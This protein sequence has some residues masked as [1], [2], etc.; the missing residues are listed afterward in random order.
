MKNIIQQE[1]KKIGKSQQQLAK[2]VG[3]T[4]PALSNIERGEVVPSGDVLLKICKAI[5]KP[6][7]ELFFY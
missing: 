7:E 6:V 4:R 5:G 3:I 2:D 1:R